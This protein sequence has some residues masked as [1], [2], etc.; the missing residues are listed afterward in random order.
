MNLEQRVERL[1]RENRRLRIGGRGRAADAASYI[2]AGI[3]FCFMTQ[4]GRY[5][6]IVKHDLDACRVVQDTYFSPGG[7]SGV[8]GLTG[9]ADAVE[10][11]VFLETADHDTFARTALDISEQTCFLHALCRTDLETNVDVRSV[12]GEL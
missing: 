12:V 8:A 2:S 3:A 9:V 6:D 5:A 1:E 11:H 7:V 4:F 10:T